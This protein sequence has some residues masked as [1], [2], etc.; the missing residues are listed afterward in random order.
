M[1]C[2]VHTF[3]NTRYSTSAMRVEVNCANCTKQLIL[4][5]DKPVKACKCKNLFFCSDYCYNVVIKAHKK[6]CPGNGY[7][8]KCHFIYFSIIFF[9]AHAKNKDSAFTT[10][11]RK[12]MP[13]TSAP[14][15]Q[16]NMVN[17]QGAS[18]PISHPSPQS[19][20]QPSL[21]TLGNTS[22]SPES[23]LPSQI[24]LPPQVCGT[25]PTVL[26][27]TDPQIRDEFGRFKASR[28]A[29]GVKSQGQTLKN[30]ISSNITKWKANITKNCERIQTAR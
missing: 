24:D 8:Y 23:T 17:T 11:A 1:K 4:Y 28:P 12:D 20:P 30:N 22:H 29:T 19:I 10:P 13:T 21:L 14:A 3:R 6:V 27:G 5:G 7:K 2:T 26:S 16:I 15:V 9:K 18:H 25:G